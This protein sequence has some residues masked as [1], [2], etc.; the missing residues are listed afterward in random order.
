MFERI[1]EII[2]FVIAE[3][4]YDSDLTK[5]DVK[6]LEKLGYSTSEISTAFS[7]LVDK[8]T[9]DEV[10]SIPNESIK[11]KS[12][13]VF[14]ESE[15]EIFTKEALGELTQLN[16]LGLINSIEI[17]Y[18]IERVLISGSPEVDK[19]MLSDMLGSILFNNMDSGYYGSRLIL[20]GNE[21]IN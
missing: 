8:M 11:E 4:K 18:L 12:L 9:Y 20:T 10:N 2:L 13:R 5:V 21:T 16:T 14:D 17:E 7:W 1:F 6:K 15:K 3:L 19:K